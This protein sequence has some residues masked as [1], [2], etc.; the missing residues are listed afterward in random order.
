MS[1]F[2]LFHAPKTLATTV[3]LTVA[4]TLVPLLWLPVTVVLVGTTLY[5]LMLVAFALI[6]YCVEYNDIGML[7]LAGMFVAFGVAVSIMAD[8][9]A[10]QPETAFR[11]AAVLTVL[12]LVTALAVPLVA[13]LCKEG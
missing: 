2:D 3:I 5:M 11:Y 13:M 1:M 7:Y 6:F 8:V 10:V 4:I 12:A 9:G